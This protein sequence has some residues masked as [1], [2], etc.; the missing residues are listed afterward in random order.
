MLSLLGHAARV[1]LLLRIGFFQ[2]A[3]AV[4]PWVVLVELSRSTRSSTWTGLPRKRR[5][6]SQPSCRQKDFSLA[7]LTDLRSP[8]EAFVL[9]TR[10]QPSPLGT[11]HHLALSTKRCCVFLAAL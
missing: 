8:T 3:A 5:N 9:H 10:R 7:R 6:R 11:A 2:C 4:V 1:Q